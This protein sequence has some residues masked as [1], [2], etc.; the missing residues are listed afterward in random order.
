MFDKLTFRAG[1]T[2][3]LI[4]LC[5]LGMLVIWAG[6]EMPA[7]TLALP[8]P[9][10]FPIALGTLLALVSFASLFF[11]AK[12]EQKSVD[13]SHRKVWIVLA[14]L[15]AAAFFFERF[16]AIPSL[17]VFLSV[18]MFL[19]ADASWLRAT[20]WGVLGGALLWFVFVYLLGVTL[21]GA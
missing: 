9:G 3:V 17:S 13:F 7:G 15:A 4:A 10:F 12:S 18:L 14:A 6:R 5:V 2:S 11:R 16:G 1:E 21:P 20:L 8:G 19:L